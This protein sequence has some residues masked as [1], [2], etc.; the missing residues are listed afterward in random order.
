MLSDRPSLFVDGW[1]EYDGMIFTSS[2][3]RILY[4]GYVWANSIHRPT[5]KIRIKLWQL[6]PHIE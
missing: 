2:A 3:I 5:L 6:I 1:A 4:L